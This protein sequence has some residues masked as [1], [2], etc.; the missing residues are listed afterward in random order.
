MHF[1]ICPAL[2]RC[3]I[4]FT[5]RCSRRGLYHELWS[6][7]SGFTLSED[8]RRAECSPQRLRSIPLLQHLD[9]QRLEAIA[10]RLVSES[11]ASDRVIF[12][13]GD[14]GDKFYLIV[15]PRRSLGC[16]AHRRRDG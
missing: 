5:S 10:Q 8:G 6:K 13:D 11:Y 4:L 14:P 15:R 9:D 1:W 12:E 7:Q 2:R 16:R 3:T